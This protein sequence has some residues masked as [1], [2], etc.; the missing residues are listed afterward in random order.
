MLVKVQST[1]F[2]NL[3]SSLKSA[4]ANGIIDGD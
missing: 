4:T 1:P 3:Y 2:K